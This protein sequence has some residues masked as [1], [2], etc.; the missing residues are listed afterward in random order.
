MSEETPQ[1]RVHAVVCDLGA[2][3]EILDALITASEPVPL[4]WMH[5]WVKR[6]HTELDMAWLAL[7]EGRRERAK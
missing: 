5:K 4:E 2:L 6:L 3:A 7:P 1:T